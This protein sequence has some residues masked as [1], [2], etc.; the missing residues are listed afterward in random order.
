M[1][2]RQLEVSALCT[3]R[4]SGGKGEKIPP[5]P[6]RKPSPGHF[7]MAAFTLIVTSVSLKVDVL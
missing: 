7:E 6:Q 1:M 3:E 4:K 5:D 2:N